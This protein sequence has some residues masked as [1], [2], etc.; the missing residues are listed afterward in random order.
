MKVGDTIYYSTYV[1]G[2]GYGPVLETEV[3][4]VGKKYFKTKL[5][6][7]T[8]IEIESM[9]S[10]NLSNFSNDNHTRY[11]NNPQ[12]FQDFIDK[13]QLKKEIRNF[14]SNFQNLENLGVNTLRQI[15]TLMG[16]K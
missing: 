9:Q 10:A 2:T 14:V 7:N 3:T 6:P 5:Y 1:R 13:I 8:N 12:E 4:K 15:R 16:I 11:F